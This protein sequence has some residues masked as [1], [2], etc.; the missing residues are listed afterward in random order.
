MLFIQ[1][2]NLVVL[3]VKYMFLC[4][5]QWQVQSILSWIYKTLIY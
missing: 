2:D 3:I 5:S 4:L 1:T